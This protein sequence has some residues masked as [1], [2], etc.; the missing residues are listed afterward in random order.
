M[1]WRKKLFKD[2]VQFPPRVTLEKGKSYSFI[3]MEVLDGITKYVSPKAE[4]IWTGSGGAKFEDGDTLFARITP[5]LQNGKISQVKNLKGGKGFGSTEYFIFRG[6]PNVSDSDFLYYLSRTEEFRGYAIGSMVGASGRQRAD[7]T[8]V[9]QFEVN[10]PDLP[11]QTRIASVLSAYD[12]LIENNLKRIKLLEEFAQRTYEEWFVKFRVNGE[13]LAINEDTGLPEDWERKRLRDLVDYEIGGGWGEAEQ[14]ND[15]SEPGYVIRG[16]DID[17][18]YIGSIKNVPFRFHKKSN[19][20]SRKIQAGD[21]VF[22]VSGGS[23]FEGVAKSLLVT[24]ELLRQFDNDVMCASFCKLVR[25]SK[26]ELS[27]ILYLTFRFFRKVKTTEIWEIRS[28]SNIVNYNWT[29]FLAFQKTILPS[30][31]ILD[32]FNEV[33]SPL[34]KQL[35]NVGNQ[36]NLLKQSRDILLPRLMNGTIS[37]EQAEESFA[38][39]AEPKVEYIKLKADY[40]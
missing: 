9:G 2:I 33:I 39:A 16:T 7:A 18:L 19:M 21:I 14:T 29:A 31:R 23:S 4:K 34:Y 30:G 24:D 25:P 22:E 13:G 17:P 28:A 5:C 20:S 3:P 37:V 27:N 15:C 10:L 12:D 35:F 36:N 26:T 6:I 11:T 40:E 1:T 8:F 32:A 38:M